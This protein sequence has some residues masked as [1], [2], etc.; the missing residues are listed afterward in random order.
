MVMKNKINKTGGNK[1]K[2]IVLGAGKGTR[3]QSEKSNLPKVL[4]QANGKSL[5]SYVLEALSFIP[6][7]DICLVVGYKKELVKDEIQG[8]YQYVSQDEQLGT[9]HAVMMA[10]P[11]F[12]DLLNAS[13]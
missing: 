2:A 3:L 5:M 9:G 4:H 12:K 13:S 7:E 10:E 1:M 6:Q 11:C 8:E